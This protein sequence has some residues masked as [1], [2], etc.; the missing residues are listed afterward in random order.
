MM[1]DMLKTV[2][3]SGTGTAA[4]S[5]NIVVAG[6]TGTTNKTKDLWFCGY[7]SYYTTSVWIGYDYPKDMSGTSVNA[8]TI[9]KNF[10]VKIHENL[11]K[12]DFPKYS[13]NTTQ[14]E[15]QSETQPETES[16]TETQSETESA[17]T[18]KTSSQTTTKANG[19][20]SS[21]GNNGNNSNSRPNNTQGEWDATISGGD[22]DA[23]TVTDRDATIKGGDW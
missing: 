1:T 22:R 4:Y 10:M 7:S 16:I 19:N 6:K 11:P 21:G 23:E 13:G 17:S 2:V 3:E 20:T 8:G 12:K 15:T 9:F 14:T 5:D 18:E